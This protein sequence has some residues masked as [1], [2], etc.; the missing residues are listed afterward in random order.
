[1][2]PRRLLCLGLAVTIL[3]FSAS[4]IDHSAV[5]QEPTPTATPAPLTP[6]PT[7]IGNGGNATWT[8]N[9]NTF[10]SDYPTGFSFALDISSSGGKIASASI[11]WRHGQAGAFRYPATINSSDV[12]G[13][14]SYRW[15]P[16]RGDGVPQ[17]VSVEYW[18]LLTDTAGNSY[19]TPRSY[20]EYADNT[21]KWQ[22]LES[23]DIIVFWEA[24]LPPSLGAQVIAA[25]K[26]QRPFYLL[27]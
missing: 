14:V 25:M 5:A 8:I 18:W 12:S 23:D 1:M 17:W 21:R 6:L 26:K 20:A 3:F 11:F 7:P 2:S 16:F 15:T 4:I 22:R 24:R 9:S 19:E 13:N 10:N 27:N